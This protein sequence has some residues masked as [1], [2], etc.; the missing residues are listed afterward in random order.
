MPVL[1][2]ANQFVPPDLA[3]TARLLGEL[4]QGLGE[5]G[6]R[7][8]L[9]GRSASYRAGSVTGLRRWLRDLV[10][11]VGLFVKG[12]SGPRPD[13]ILCLT[14]PPAL[15][16]TMKCLAFCR[17]SRLVHWPMDVYPQIAAALGALKKD[18]LIYCTIA[19]LSAWALHKSDAVV[20]LDDDMRKAL[21]PAASSTTVIPP[22]V[23]QDIVIPEALAFPDGPKIKWLYS[24]NLGRAHDFETLLQAQRILEDADAPFE[25]V[26]QGGG[27]CREAAQQLATHLGLR[28]CQWLEYVQDVQLIP[29]LLLAHVLVATQREATRGLLWPSKLALLQALPRPIAWVGAPAGAIAASLRTRSG[30]TGIFAPGDAAGLAAWLM[31]HAEDFRSAARRPVSSQF[32]R[33]QLANQR[34]NSTEAWHHLLSQM[35]SSGRCA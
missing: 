1:W 28:S 19:H 8:R 14:D 12:L 3:P 4:S 9:L 33:E 11:H 13:I 35:L 27:A 17:G 32:I 23:P 2:L 10:A 16:F 25:L 15:V 6:W 7:I 31:E 5:R 30:S 26:F 24:G 22:W 29:S 18:S 34:N 21:L 20:C